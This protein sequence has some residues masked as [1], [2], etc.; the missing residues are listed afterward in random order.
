MNPSLHLSLPRRPAGQV[1]D[2]YRP[3]MRLAFRATAGAHGTHAARHVLLR[4]APSEDDHSEAQRNGRRWMRR[5]MCGRGA[6]PPSNL[7]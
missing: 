1:I 2:Q 7:L 4:S 3:A 6:P 5:P